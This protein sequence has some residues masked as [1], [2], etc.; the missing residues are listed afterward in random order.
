MKDKEAWDI[1]W[2][3]VYFEDHPSQKKRR[4]V[5]VLEDDGLCILSLK[6]TTHG[7]RSFDPCDYELQYWKEAG[8]A[9]PSVVR[10]AHVAYL[11]EDD[12]HEKLG[13]LENADILGLQYKIQLR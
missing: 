12:F 6:V 2:A 9:F 3:D 1:W 11:R 7:P 10:V 13:R 5:V 4:P 8:L